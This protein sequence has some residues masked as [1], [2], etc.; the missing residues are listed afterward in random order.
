MRR[1]FEKTGLEDDADV[2]ADTDYMKSNMRR[3]LD[4]TGLIDD[5]AA[6]AA[7]PVPKLTANDDH[8]EEEA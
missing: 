3:I 4:K 8:W 6:D 5:D 7:A 1:V 2:A